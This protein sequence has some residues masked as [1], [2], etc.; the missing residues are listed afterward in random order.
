M[1]QWKNGE[2]ETAI[3]NKLAV[4]PMSIEEFSPNDIK[5][6][7]MAETKKAVSDSSLHSAIRKLQNNGFIAKGERGYYRRN[8]EKILE[9]VTEEPAVTIEEKPKPVIS[10]GKMKA[11]EVGFYII[12]A[13]RALIEKPTVELDE[14]IKRNCSMQEKIQQLVE[15]NN[16]LRRQ[17]FEKANRIKKYEEE[18]AK[19]VGELDMGMLREAYE[20]RQA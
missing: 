18:L 3:L 10:I 16:S 14:Q 6:G 5:R 19:H 7:L 1:K 2:M 9:R 4:M 11:A 15:E 13:V 20:L 17:I 8:I 12:E